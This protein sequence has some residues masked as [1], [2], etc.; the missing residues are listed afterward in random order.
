[1]GG[2]PAVPAQTSS[3]SIHEMDPR[4]FEMLYGSKGAP[5][6]QV[7]MSSARN[8]RLMNQVQKGNQQATEKFYGAAP[9]A[10]LTA[11]KNAL[12]TANPGQQVRLAKG[13]KA[14][15][16]QNVPFT[17]AEQYNVVPFFDPNTM[18]STNPY[19]NQAINQLQSMGQSPWQYDAASKGFQGLA[20]KAW[21]DPGVAQSYMNPYIENNLKI[22]EDL[23][24]RQFAQQQNQLNSQAA[25]RGAFGGSAS[26]LA[27]QNAQYNQNLAN[28][29]RVAQGMNDAYNFGMQG[30]QN[31]MGRQLQAN[32]GLLGAG[33]QQAAYNQNLFQNWGQAGNTLQNLAQNWYGNRA[34]N[35]NQFW[36]GVGSAAAPGTSLALQ[37]PWQSSGSSN[38]QFT[39][40][41]R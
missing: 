25:G 40:G 37:T 34:Q 41:T 10:D 22:Q 16:Q 30:F 27:Q 29:N 28:Q 11:Y 6:S 36:N 1:M 23:A 33:G 35:A 38:Q 31:D 5:G 39:G 18:Q 2:A 4:L 8:A 32:Q 9:G 7:M 26:A 13:G 19:Y 17:R 21:T 12:G 3:T 14:A 20:N 15:K 24:N